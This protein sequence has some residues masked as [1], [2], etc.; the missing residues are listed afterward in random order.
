M[1]RI[2]TLLT[3]RAH[4]DVFSTAKGTIPMSIRDL[5]S[6][7]LIGAVASARSMTPMATIAAARAGGN[8]SKRLYKPFWRVGNRDFQQLAERSRERQNG[9]M[10]VLGSGKP[11]KR[12]LPHFDLAH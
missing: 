7:I 3:Y 8:P 10:A 2:I 12:G 4:H 9:R 11:Q 1:A 6:S 5:L